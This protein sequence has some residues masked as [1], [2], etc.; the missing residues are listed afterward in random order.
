MYY[1]RFVFLPVPVA[2]QGDEK[3]YTAGEKDD[4][5]TE[6]KQ[7]VVGKA[8]RD[9]EYGADQEQKPAGKVIA[10]LPFTD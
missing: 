3:G 6:T 7:I 4:A 1:I 10:F 2:H 8:L 5:A 9:E